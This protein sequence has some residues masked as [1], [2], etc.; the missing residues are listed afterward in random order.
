MAFATS[1]LLRQN[2]SQMLADVE[3]K[4]QDIDVRDATI[5]G[6]SS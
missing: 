5:L 1:K 6:V 4:V 2:T 3:K